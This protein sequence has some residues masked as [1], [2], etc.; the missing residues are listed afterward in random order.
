MFESFFCP[1][2]SLNDRIPPRDDLSV[3]LVRNRERKLAMKKRIRIGIAFAAVMLASTAA[4]QQSG[5][6]AVETTGPEK[7]TLVVVGGG[8]LSDG[9]VNRFIELAGGPDASIVVVPTAGGR[10]T[11][12]D[13]VT[14]FLRNRGVRNVTMLHT[15]DRAV[16]NSEQFVAPLKAANAVWFSGGRQWR[17][18]D[19]YSGTLAEKMFREVLK[20]G[21]VV[22]GSSA[23]A[24][25]QG[26]YLARG[27][28]K[29]NQ[30]MMG[31]HEKGFGYIKNVAIDQHVLARNRQ[32]DMFD[33]L[34]N[35]PE[36]LGLGID[37]NTAIV[38][39]GNEFEVIGSS[40]VLVY[41]GS[42]WSREG[43]GL[44]TIPGKRTRFYF[45]RRG[46]R[47]DLRKRQ[48]IRRR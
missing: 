14:A 1:F 38:V 36:L 47:Y 26:S 5:A 37:E 34:K 18:V 39:K 15:D 13:R 22:G 43:S 33:I 46:D 2:V 4:G 20:R 48:V 29:N 11:Y 25:I 19:A 10:E 41:D 8:R 45:L 28:T 21:G 17:L 24:T 7:G 27:D 23:G 44:K 35:R 9:I 16:A 31:D 40:Y 42:F 12:T 3:C 32:F 6:G 30:I